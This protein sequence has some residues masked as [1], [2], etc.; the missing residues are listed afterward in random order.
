MTKK[1]TKN[2]VMVSLAINFLEKLPE[3]IVKFLMSIIGPKTKN[4]KMEIGLQNFVQQWHLTR[5][6][7]IAERPFPLKVI[8]RE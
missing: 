7:E 3:S 1:Q 4:P 8:S 5:N 6:K 2:T